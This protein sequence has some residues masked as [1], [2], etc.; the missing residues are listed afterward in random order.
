[1][2]AD[3]PSAITDRLLAPFRKKQPGARLPHARLHALIRRIFAAALKRDFD[4]RRI[5]AGRHHCA[6]GDKALLSQFPSRHFERKN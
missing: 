1:M 3:Q 4:T 5:I 2:H 6:D